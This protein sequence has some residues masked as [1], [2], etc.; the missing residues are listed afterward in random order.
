[1]RARRQPQCSR[2]RR[3]S[4]EIPPRGLSPRDNGQEN[5]PPIVGPPDAMTTFDAEDADTNQGADLQELETDCASGHSSRLAK[6]ARALVRIRVP[7][8][9]WKALQ[10]LFP[11]HP[12]PG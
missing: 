12:W 11:R 10:K 7:N 8:R 5:A 2:N 3:G 9:I 4:G 6:A 1:M